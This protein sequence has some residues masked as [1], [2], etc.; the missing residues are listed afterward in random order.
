MNGII[1]ACGGALI[2]AIVSL[3]TLFAQRKWQK[4]D[5]RSAKFD[6]VLSEIGGLKTSL[7]DHIEEQDMSDAR[8]ARRRILEFSDECRRGIK[9]S[10]EHFEN[11]LTEDVDLYEKYCKSHPKFANSKCVLSINL[12]KELYAKTTKDNDFI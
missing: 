9:H 6:Q 7:K 5:R 2:A 8:R 11:V 3:I 10:S 1:V 4:E 12:I